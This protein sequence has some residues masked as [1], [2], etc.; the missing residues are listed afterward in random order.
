MRSWPY[1][2]LN[3]EK[4]ADQ[5]TNVQAVRPA[6]TR[7]SH[8]CNQDK[9]TPIIAI[10]M[11]FGRE[12]VC[13]RDYDR[14]LNR[15]QTTPSKSSI[16]IQTNNLFVQGQRDR[17]IDST[18]INVIEQRHCNMFR[19]TMRV[20]LCRSNPNNTF[21]VKRTAIQTHLLFVQ[22]QRYRTM[23]RC[24]QDKRTPII[25]IVM[26]FA[27]DECACKIMTHLDVKHSKIQTYR[28][29]VQSQRDRVIDATKINA[30][31][32]S[33]LWYIVIGNEGQITASHCIGPVWHLKIQTLRNADK[34]KH[35]IWSSR[36]N[37]IVP[38]IQKRPTIVIAVYFDKEWW[39]ACNLTLDWTRTPASNSSA[40]E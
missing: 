32:P 15:I 31:R 38:S 20:T 30:H 27:E 14:T 7:S 21:K 10:V 33:P 19:K 34:Y 1:T 35:T 36:A 37:E 2:G 12:W 16:A 23:H 40:Q 6:S 4:Q 25:V 13:M 26:Y 5:H 9:R 28:L 22:G 11:Y 3:L 24:N 17:A 39:G 29:F 8:W 18:K